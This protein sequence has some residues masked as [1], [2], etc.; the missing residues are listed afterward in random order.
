MR[1]GLA[2]GYYGK[3]TGEAEELD[4]VRNREI[5]THTYNII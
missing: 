5:Y 4:K 1:A 3:F 2:K